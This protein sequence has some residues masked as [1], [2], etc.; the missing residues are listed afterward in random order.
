[1]HWKLIVKKKTTKHTLVAQDV[2]REGEKEEKNKIQVDGKIRQRKR[3][4]G[5]YGTKWI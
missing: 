1:M 5:K 4:K 3:K 2:L